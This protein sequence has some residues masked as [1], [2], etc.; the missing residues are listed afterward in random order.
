MEIIRSTK[1]AGIH[2]KK[3]DPDP[4]FNRW[5]SCVALGSVDQPELTGQPCYQHKT[6]RHLVKVPHDRIPPKVCPWC[7]VDTAKEQHEI[8]IAERNGIK[9]FDGPQRNLAPNGKSD[10]SQTDEIT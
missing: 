7:N 5:E 1:K 4:Y 6:C 2:T 8:E 10:R 9:I 3:I